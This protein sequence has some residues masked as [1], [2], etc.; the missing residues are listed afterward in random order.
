MSA[1]TLTEIKDYLQIT[2]TTYD[3]RINLLMPWV[4]D[5]LFNG[6]LHRNF[7]DSDD[8]AQTPLG[9]RI[10]LAQMINQHIAV[11]VKT[12]D[13]TDKILTSI[14]DLSYKV[15]T[16]SDQIGGYPPSII[17]SSVLRY[18]AMSRGW[19]GSQEPSISGYT[20]TTNISLGTGDGAETEF[21]YSGIILE[22]TEQIYTGNLP[23]KRTEH[24]TIDGSVVTFLTAPLDGLALTFNGWVK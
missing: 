23:A 13:E 7:I 6:I 11:G 21:T 16:G 9:L 22:G 20:P 17:N 15:Y 3:D 5:Q 24:Y 4:E 8:V 19:E 14:G 1:I 18:R 10:T 2:D 12:T